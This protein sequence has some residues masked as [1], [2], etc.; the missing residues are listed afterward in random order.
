MLTRRSSHKL[1]GVLASLVLAVTGMSTL[2]A[3]AASKATVI[4]HTVCP[5][6]TGTLTFVGSMP[7]EP[8][9]G[10]AYK[11]YLAEWAK[12]CPK[13][14]IQVS[15]ITNNDLNAKLTVLAISKNLPDLFEVS[16]AQAIALS[17][18]GSIANLNPILGAAFVK[19]FQKTNIDNA[20]FNGKL[21]Y[22]PLMSIPMAVLYRRS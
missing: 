6:F 12:T 1:I 7:T 8:K 18:S 14:K 19:G 16:T 15:G 4:G 13:T 2:V 9:E 5:R 10:A 21:L 11:E 17:N 20:S 22:A 3:S